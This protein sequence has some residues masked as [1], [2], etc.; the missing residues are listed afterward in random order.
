MF[1]EI[2]RR[3]GYMNI[4]S[5]NNRLQE[6]MKEK[7]DWQK[8]LD[9]Y[10]DGGI[11]TQQ[12]ILNQLSNT[13]WNIDKVEKVVN[14]YNAAMES[15]RKINKYK[16]DISKATSKEEIEKLND[17][18]KKE[19]EIQE[20]NKSIL[21]NSASEVFKELNENIKNMEHYNKIAP[22]HN[23]D[24]L[25]FNPIIEKYNSQVDK[26][27]AL[28]DSDNFAERK[29]EYAANL[30][31]LIEIKEKLIQNVEEKVKKVNQRIEELEKRERELVSSAIGP[32]GLK[33]DENNRVILS[34]DQKELFKKRADL[35]NEKNKAKSLLN[36]FNLFKDSIK[37]TQ[38]EQELLDRGLTSKQI[39]IYIEIRSHEDDEKKRK[40][41]D[42]KPKGIDFAPYESSYRKR[43]EIYDALL[44]DYNKDLDALK[45]LGE[46]YINGEVTYD[47][48][49]RFADS[50]QEK[51][52]NVK[53]MYDKI[54][55]EYNTIKDEV[56][57][58]K[59]WHPGLSSEEIEELKKKG[60][61]P[62]DDKYSEYLNSKGLTVDDIY[63]PVEPS[64]AEVLSERVITKDEEPVKVVKTTP[65]QW[66]KDHKKQILIALGITA[67]AVSAAVVFTQLLP[68]L[69]AA[70][71]ATFT[72]GLI[73]QMLAN[74]NAW[75]LASAA[76]KA[77]LHAANTT[78]FNLTG[79]S[80]AFNGLSGA[81]TLGGH[82][83]AGAAKIASLAAFK[84]QSAAVAA[85]NLVTAA[86]IGGLGLI[87]A[88]LFIPN[89][90]AEY[91]STITEIKDLKSKIGITSSEEI[92]QGI[93]K[94][95]NDVT[96]SK[97]LSNAE[98]K[99]LLKR[100]KSLAKKSSMSKQ[101][102][103]NL[104]PEVDEP[105]IMDTVENTMTENPGRGGR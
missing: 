58:N 12:D 29:D 104:E 3:D 45:E 26:I 89:R 48:Y 90:S 96:S 25:D 65:W 57:N 22:L 73:S 105:E 82:G 59:K 8:R 43:A 53:E 16:D 71:Q 52:K 70:K 28:K 66:I 31:Y 72:S 92:N 33:Y 11:L 60:I 13:D 62:G 81:W 85:Q 49:K 44:K 80:G 14:A 24:L 93:L 63:S 32:E 17:E 87:G 50:V 88:G 91:K 102:T 61:K 54:S 98:K 23:P 97:T 86:G 47:E 21:E 83:L 35:E 51:Y 36:D 30:F 20:S 78:L 2:I 4:E 37:L 10:Q 15:T 100:L 42:E 39:K 68:A 77:A 74:S 19:Q 34:E 95:E 55:E 27:N 41:E 84:A 67:L 64:E 75:H 101:N 5:Y 38:E 40:E 94:I 76:E 99:V 46:K 79:M 56:A 18:I 103:N 9:E 69:M 1:I 7:S 6:L